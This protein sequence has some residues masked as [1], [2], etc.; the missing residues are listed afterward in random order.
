MKSQN[1]PDRVNWEQ[2]ARAEVP[3]L[4]VSILEVLSIDGGRTL[5]PNEL[6]YELQTSLTTVNHHTTRL[7][8][9]G[10]LRLAHERQV[11]GTMEHFYCSAAHTAKDLFD[12]L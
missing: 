10:I 7:V 6:A 3:Q 11:R 2:L 12:R 5:A 8:R 1:D 9:L 4:R